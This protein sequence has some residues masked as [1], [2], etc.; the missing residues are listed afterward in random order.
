MTL[1]CYMNT[2]CQ[3]IWL[4]LCLVIAGVKP[5][6][7]QPSITST[8]TTNTNNLD[9]DGEGSA[10]THIVK[11]ADL[12]VSTANANGYTLTVSSGDLSKFGGT[13]IGFQVT[14]VADDA[15]TPDA[16]DFTTPIGDDYNLSTNTAGT[17]NLDL[18]VKY[19][20]ANL[21]DPGTYTSTINLTVTDNP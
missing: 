8:S 1:A 11:V 19:T 15:P 7:A 9:L 10:E 6:F 21:Q 20:P 18:Y 13:E 12:T 2:P 5:V 16:A 3:L 4:A 17:E 14:T